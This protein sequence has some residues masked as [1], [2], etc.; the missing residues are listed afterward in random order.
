MSLHEHQKFTEQQEAIKNYQ[1]Q[2]YFEDLRN[3][4]KT[5]DLKIDSGWTHKIKGDYIYIDGS[6]TNI[7]SKFIVYYEIGVEF[8]DLTGK[9]VDTDWTNGT[10]VSS[11]TS[12]EFSLMHKWNSKYSKI[13][14]YIKEVS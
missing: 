3:T 11:Y 14:L 2:K 10:D 5:S 13:N 7:S 6:V 12:Q 1:T 9:V 8:L 4:P